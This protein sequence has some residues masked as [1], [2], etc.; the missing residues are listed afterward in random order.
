[1]TTIIEQVRDISI[2]CPI[3]NSQKQLKIPESIVKKANQLTTISLPKGV[4]CDHHFQMFVDRNFKVRGYQK[5]DF[6][7]TRPKNNKTA[8]NKSANENSDSELFNSILYDG[9]YV[10]YQPLKHQ[11]NHT[12]V[13]EVKS[14]L[15]V[16]YKNSLKEIYEDFWE[17]IE[18]DNLEFKQFIEKDPRRRRNIIRE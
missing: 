14:E 12:S 15:Q 3:C 11:E 9:N 13:T 10:K 4:L 1:M 7:L 6:E 16:R 5:V 18:D 8:L 17:Y 2:R